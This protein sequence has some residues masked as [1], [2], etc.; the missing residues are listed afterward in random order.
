MYIKPIL[1]GGSVFE[2]TALF[3]A[4]PFSSAQ[5]GVPSGLIMQVKPLVPACRDFGLPSCIMTI[6]AWAT[7]CS[8]AA[9][10]TLARY[11][12]SEVGT[13]SV[14]NASATPVPMNRANVEESD[15]PPRKW[16]GLGR[17][18]LSDSW[19]DVAQGRM[20]AA[21]IVE[22]LDILE[23]VSTG[24]GAGAINPIVNPLGL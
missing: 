2:R 7:I 17:H 8:G 21:G 3:H 23:E 4:M 12:A 18:T 13:S 9:V 10:L 15:L 20:Q 1:F 22:A 16:T 6:V 24:V 14:G 19:A 5:S 11:A